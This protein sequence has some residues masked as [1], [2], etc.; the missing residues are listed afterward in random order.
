MFFFLPNPNPPSRL[1]IA[2]DTPALATCPALGVAGPESPGVGASDAAGSGWPLTVVPRRTTCIIGT[3]F[4]FCI[5][6]A[7]SLSASLAPGFCES[8]LLKS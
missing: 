4:S 7:I 8:I 6:P 5:S 2:E 3:P 1:E